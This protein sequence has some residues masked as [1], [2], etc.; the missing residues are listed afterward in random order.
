MLNFNFIINTTQ[1]RYP[2]PIF[3]LESTNCDEILTKFET[4]NKNYFDKLKPKDI[5]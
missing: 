3:K 2:D 5:T 1:Y 4:L